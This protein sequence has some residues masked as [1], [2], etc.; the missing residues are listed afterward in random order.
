M[1]GATRI[2]KNEIKSR[3]MKILLIS[4]ILWE[5]PTQIINIK[6]KK[7][8]NRL[9]YFKNKISKIEPSLILFAGDVI[10]DGSCRYEHVD[11]FLELLKFLEKKKIYSYIIQGNHDEYSNY[12]KLLKGIG[13]LSY[14]E[15]I[16]NKIVEFNNLKIL[17]VPFSVTNNLKNL[18][19]I[20]EKFPKVD[21]V[22]AHSQYSRRIWLFELKSKFIITGHFDEQLCRIFNKVFIALSHFPTNYAILDYEK[23]DQTVTYF[24]TPQFGEN[25]E[26]VSQVKLTNHIFVW[27]MDEYPKDNIFLIKPLKY[28]KYSIMVENL[29]SAKKR[30]IEGNVNKQKGIIANLL[31]L[32]IPKNHIEEYIGK[33]RLLYNYS[34]KRRP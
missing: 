20:N 17:G 14:A 2:I 34:N 10:N 27:K 13:K 1:K 5:D 11:E 30:I 16:S 8:K 32:G 4:D 23:H 24:R 9:E 33:K 31:K 3:Y 22:L 6:I 15:E 25:K 7:Q 26:Y 21:I 18:R 12:D 19:Q 29:I 28:S